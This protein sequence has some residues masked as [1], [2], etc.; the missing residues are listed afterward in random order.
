LVIAGVL[1]AGACGEPTQPVTLPTCGNG[2]VDPGETCDG[3]C[4]TTCDDAVACTTDRLVG[5][6]AACTAACELAPIEVCADDDGCCAGGCNALT[7]NDCSPTC[8][9]GQVEDGETCDGA[10]CVSACNDGNACTADTLVGSPSSCSAACSFEPIVAC[11][12]GD[13][14]CPAGCNV[15]SDSDCSAF[16]GDDVLSPGET[17]DGAACP[18]A[19]SDGNACTLDVL[20]GSASSCSAAC[21]FA[22][23]TACSDGDGCCAPGCNA[24]TDDDCSPTCGNDVLEAGEVCD[25][26]CPTTC[27]DG[28]AC[29]IDTLVGSAASCSAACSFQPITQC[30]SGDGCCAPGCNANLDTDCSPTC[31]NGEVEP[32]EICDG[33]SCP[34]SCSDGN[35]CTIDI[36][37]GD[38]TSCS[39]T[40]STQPI[41]QCG[42]PD[43]CCPGGCT[44]STDGDCM[45]GSSPIG[46]PCVQPADCASQACAPESNGFPGG[47]CFGI[48]STDANCPAG[49]H[50]GFG[51]A[52]VDSCMAS[53][54]CRAGYGCA[55]LD[56]DLRRECMPQQP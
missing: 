9:N 17:C 38:A 7:D 6:A 8:G 13:G 21:T 40:C 30:A 39:A 52:C 43:G 23:V 20:A 47:Y 42:A 31:G 54:E 51:G 1:I 55:D 28:G 18:T 49:S 24:N 3:D 12:S 45:P 26:D 14:C 4:V 2:I 11:Q 15:A 33:A 48:C 36:L 35:A 37:S 5:S 16:C 27:N 56:G 25:G 53:T 29:T 41:T 46:G 10:S 32:G 34:T 22:P 44:A 50:C 19:C